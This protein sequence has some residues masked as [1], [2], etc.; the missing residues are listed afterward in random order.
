M[1]LFKR[2]NR[3][4]KILESIECH[5]ELIVLGLG[6]LNKVADQWNVQEIKEGEEIPAA[7]VRTL[8]NE[9][10]VELERIRTG[11]TGVAMAGWSK[12]N[13]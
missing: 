11:E 3:Q 12:L 4:L 9:Q 6:R 2:D 8:T 7:T 10:M 5:L 1:S 13:V